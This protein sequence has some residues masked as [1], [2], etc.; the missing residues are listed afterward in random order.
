MASPGGAP[1][2]PAPAYELPDPPRHA[3]E[4]KRCLFCN[5]VLT[6]RWKRCGGCRAA[7]FCSRDHFE[8]AWPAHAA[9]CLV[10]QER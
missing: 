2:P 1:P 9:A 4:P 10:V 5:V 7:Y 6:G 3:V 8:A